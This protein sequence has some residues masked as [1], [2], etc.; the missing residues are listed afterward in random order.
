MKLYLDE[1]L[2]P[3]LARMLRARGIDCQTAVEAGNLGRSDEEQLT[4]ATSQG[5]VLVTFDRADFL[6]LATQWAERGRIHAGLILSRQGSAAELL[7]QLLHLI[8]LRGK[9]DLT[10]HILWLQNYKDAPRP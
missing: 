10:N 6:A 1:H 7:R 2:S 5:R 8:A 9:D 4:Y 3:L